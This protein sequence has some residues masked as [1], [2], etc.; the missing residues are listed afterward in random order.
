MSVTIRVVTGVI[1]AA[2][3]L[4]WAVCAYTVVTSRFGTDPAHDPHGYGLIFGTLLGLA[5][6][7]V[8]AIVVPFA[9]PARRRSRVTLIATATYLISSALMLTA[10]FTAS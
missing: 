8:T 7:L 4:L 5:S 1:G 9:F 3:G 10:W 6:G 2:A